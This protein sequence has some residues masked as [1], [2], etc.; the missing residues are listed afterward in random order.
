MEAYPTG[1]SDFAAGLMKAKTHG[2]Q[3]ILPI[4]DMPQSGIL[5]K[6]WQSMKIPALISGFISPMTGEAHGRSSRGRSEVL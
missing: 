5:L 3:V 2:A 1:A 6:Q 4:F